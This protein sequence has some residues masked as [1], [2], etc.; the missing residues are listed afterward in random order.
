MSDGRFPVSIKAVLLIGGK[1]ALLKNARDEWELPGGRIEAGEQPERA[2]LRE[3]A[4]ELGIEAADPEILDS[5]LYTIAGQGQVLIVTYG[6]RALPGVPR[7]SGEHAQLRLF[8]AAEIAAL[9][10]PEAYKRSIRA[11]LDRLAERDIEIG[12]CR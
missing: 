5:W 11:W 3:I 1:I 4:E 6:C 10:M 12:S 9:N 8:D 2:L 7:V